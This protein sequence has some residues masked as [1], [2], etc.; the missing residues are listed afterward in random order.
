M[1]VWHTMPFRKKEMRDKEGGGGGGKTRKVAPVNAGAVSGAG[2]GSGRREQE[3][4]TVGRKVEGRGRKGSKDGKRGECRK[5]GTHER[6]KG[7]G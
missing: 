5:E 6:G 3:G 4:R 2:S 1:L 7:R